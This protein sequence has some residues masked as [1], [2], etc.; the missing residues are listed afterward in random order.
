MPPALRRL[1]LLL[2][3]EL[4]GGLSGMASKA[5]G[6]SA[7]RLPERFKIGDKARD[8]QQVARTVTNHLIG[9]MD[10]VTFDIASGRDVSHAGLLRDKSARR[11]CRTPFRVRPAKFV[12]Y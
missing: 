11:E 9:N 6:S 4:D 1:A 7:R 2:L 12:E 3:L 8:E 5:R 10:V